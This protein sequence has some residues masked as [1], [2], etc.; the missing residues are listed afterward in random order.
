MPFLCISKAFSSRGSVV[1]IPTEPAS[2]AQRKSSRSVRKAA[3][4]CTSEWCWGKGVGVSAGSLAWQAASWR[5]K[6]V[7]EHAGT[8]LCAQMPL[9]M[10]GC[11]KVRKD[12]AKS[13][14]CVVGCEGV[15]R[16]APSGEYSSA[17]APLQKEDPDSQLAFCV[18]TD[19]SVTARRNNRT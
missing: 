16:R 4:F 2:R 5:P 15:G 1:R 7:C 10:R 3:S 6:K 11:G 13:Q 9:C 19:A 8:D 12:G 14:D 18:D 17:F